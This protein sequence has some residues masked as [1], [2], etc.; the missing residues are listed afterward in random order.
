MGLV[1]KCVGRWG[2]G[3][4]EGSCGKQRCSPRGQVSEILDL[5]RVVLGLGSPRP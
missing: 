5:D 3:G 1:G 4:G 2:V